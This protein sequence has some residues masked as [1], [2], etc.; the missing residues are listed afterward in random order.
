MKYYKD[1]TRLDYSLFD[2]KAWHKGESDELKK[3]IDFG[4]YNTIFVSVNGNVTVYYEKE[5]CDEFYEAL[6]NLLEEE[7]FNEVCDSF[8]ELTS[9]DKFPDNNDEI[10]ELSV[11][12]WPCMTVLDMVS[13]Y[14]EYGNDSM[15]RRLMRLRKSTE[16][17]SY[18][19][20]SKVSEE[21]WPETYIFYKGEMI[22][23]PL[24]EFIKDNGFELI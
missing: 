23:K 11:K 24:Q 20:A 2:V 17:F 3:L 12:L 7:F 1:I 15:I 6:D 18:E 22:E 13:R 8:V 9:I 14:P 21:D 19:L 4:F 5:E 16:S 10:F